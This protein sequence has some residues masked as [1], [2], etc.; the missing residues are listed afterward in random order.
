MFGHGDA[1]HLG[2]RVVHGDEPQARVNEAQADGGGHV[3][4]AQLLP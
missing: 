2:Q 3:E 1:G 4:G